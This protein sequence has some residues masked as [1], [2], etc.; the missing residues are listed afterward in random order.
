V[1]GTP[2]RSPKTPRQKNKAQEPREKT[3]INEAPNKIQTQ[4][5]AAKKIDDP[6]LL[7]IGRK[8]TRIT[9]SD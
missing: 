9:I 2:P 5:E 3:T 8:D 4:N 7:R 6:R 1:T